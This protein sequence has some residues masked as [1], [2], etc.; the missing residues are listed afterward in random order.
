MI[1]TD[2]HTHLFLKEFDEDR[3]EVFKRARDSGI[4]RFFLPNIDSGTIN[5]LNA[6]S[7]EFN[8]CCYPLMG[9]HP[10]SVKA[11]YETQL[12]AVRTALEKT[13]YYAVGEIGLDL[14]WDKTFFEQQKD[15]FRKQVVWSIELDLPV[16]IHSRDSFNE[17]VEILEEKELEKA[18]GIFHCFTGTAEDAQKVVGLGFYMGIGGVVT[19]KNAGL[20]KTL[21]QLS[22]DNIVLETDSPYL[23]PV[24]NRGKRNESGYMLQVAEKVAEVKSISVDEVAEITTENSKK[25]FSV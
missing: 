10:G 18:R 11:D 25:V 20:D 14:Y 5:K 4:S 24:P 15:A 3:T 22:L 9:L 12:I 17:I 19:F 13:N 7:E 16:V 1:L 6:V 8:D 2:T 21:E 23:A